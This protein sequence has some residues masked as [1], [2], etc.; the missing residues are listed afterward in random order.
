MDGGSK[1]QVMGYKL[2]LFLPILKQ[3]Q[4]LSNTN[5][6]PKHCLSVVF[7]PKVSIR[8]GSGPFQYW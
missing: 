7:R 2:L 4:T 5:L 3:P 1:T 6:K 8:K